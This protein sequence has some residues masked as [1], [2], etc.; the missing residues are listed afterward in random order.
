[1]ENPFEGATVLHC[2][3][4][5]NVDIHH[6]GPNLAIC[7]NKKEIKSLIFLIC[8]IPSETMHGLLNNAV[9][10][11]CNEQEE[12]SMAIVNLNKSEEL[13]TNTTAASKYILT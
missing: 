9:H 6:V 12:H 2:E 10:E 8:K 1:M 7:F 11:L 13:V 4:C 3:L 5:Q